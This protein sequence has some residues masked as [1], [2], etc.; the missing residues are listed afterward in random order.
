MNTHQLAR[1]IWV[2]NPGLTFEEA[3]RRA[4][5]LS[6]KQTRESKQ[7]RILRVEETR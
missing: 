6:K 1:Q 2:A 4:E 5:R 7:V 3:F